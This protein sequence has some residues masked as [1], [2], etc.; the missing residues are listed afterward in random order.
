M[1]HYREG[2]LILVRLDKGDE[3]IGGLLAALK[4]EGGRGAVMVTAL[5]ALE[6]VEFAYYDPK[7]KA[8]DR[9]TLPAS[10][11]LLGL[12]GIVASS[13]AGE[14][15]PHFHVTIGGPDHKALGG[16]LFRARVSVLAEFALRAVAN[17]KMRREKEPDFGLNALRLR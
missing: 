16:H 17:P 8:Y 7:R 12:T 14:F 13:S 10:H 4:A 6:D 5:G 1:E 9:L 15:Q 3:V 11:E 2:D